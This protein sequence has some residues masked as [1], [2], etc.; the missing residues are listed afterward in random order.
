MQT[1]CGENEAFWGENE[2]ECSESSQKL[3][4]YEMTVKQISIK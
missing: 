2:H 3:F 1:K 4:E